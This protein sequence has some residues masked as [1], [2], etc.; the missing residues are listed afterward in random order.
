MPETFLF[1]IRFSQPEDTRKFGF[2]DER[3][4]QEG[5]YIVEEGNTGKNCEKVFT[6]ITFL[7]YI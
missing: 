6:R 2:I 7:T 1:L 5:G 3:E 4:K